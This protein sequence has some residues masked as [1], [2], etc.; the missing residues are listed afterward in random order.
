MSYKP[1]N[2]QQTI[3]KL[4]QNSF[5]Y[6]QTLFIRY[7]YLIYKI[8]LKTNFALLTIAFKKFNQAPKYMQHYFSIFTFYEFRFYYF[9][10]LF[11]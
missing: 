1:K 2:M 4:E 9:I 11:I 6:C 5:C 8:Y 3:K 10:S 7:I